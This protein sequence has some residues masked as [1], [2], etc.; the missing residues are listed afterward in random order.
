MVVTVKVPYHREL[1]SKALNAGKSVYCEWPLGNG[2]AE[3]VELARLAND[4][5]L[6]GVVGTQAIASPEV[7]YVRKIV[8]DGYV[9]EVLS[10]TY[11]GAGIA[12]GNDVPPAFAYAMDSKN[13]VTLLSVNGGA[14]HC[15]CSERAWTNRRGRCCAV[16]APTDRTRD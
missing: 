16:A 1:V 11:I 5:K 8:A 10:T 14:C 15:R 6:P 9:G 4:R 2:L 13:G 3:A 7:E 12:W